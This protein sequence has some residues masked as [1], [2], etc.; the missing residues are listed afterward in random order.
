MP[1]T[2]P[3]TPSVGG[4]TLAGRKVAILATHGVEQIELTSPVAALQAAGAEVAIVSLTRD[5]IQG[6]NH[7]DKAD[8][9]LVDLAVADAKA[10]IFDALVLPGGVSNPDALRMNP[11]AVRFCR[12]FFEQKKPVAA[13][14]H[15]PW[16]LAEADVLKGRRV[17]SYASIKTDLI[18]AG[19][20]WSDEAC[21]CDQGLVT[22]RTPDDLEAFNAKLIEEVAEGAHQRQ[23]A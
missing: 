21:V 9:I 13:I 1:P 17:T 8:K 18:N 7:H 5:P 14:C 4:K 6:F 22:S 19:A 10:S 11:D 23:H 2:S 20:E 12:E 15:G 16:L 3:M